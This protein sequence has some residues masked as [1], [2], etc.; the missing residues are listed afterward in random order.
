MDLSIIIPVFNEGHKIESDLDAALHFIKEQE[1]TCE[2]IVV[3]DGSTDNSLNILKEHSEFNP[4]IINVLNYQPNR[5]KGYAVKQGILMARGDNIAYLDSGNCV[6][7]SELMKGMAL[8]GNKKADIAHGS[9]HLKQSKIVIPRKWYR[10]FFSFI[11]TKFIKLNMHLPKYLTDTQCGLKL[12]RRDAAHFLYNQCQTEGFLF[13]IEIIIMAT[14]K[15]YKIVEFPIVW[16]PD[17]DSRLKLL[18]QFFL[19]FKEIHA[20]KKSIRSF[21]RTCL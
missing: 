7:Y 12:Y 10:S 1:I 18:P 8:I 14:L 6:P 17:P 2:I 3:D 19:I 9:R 20:I 5:G 16:T 4:G 13:D 11:F 21:S 15:G